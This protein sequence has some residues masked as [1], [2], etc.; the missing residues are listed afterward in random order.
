M[1]ALAAS[2]MAGA[3]QAAAMQET[4]Y[5]VAVSAP[6]VTERAQALKEEAEA[7]YSQPKK[8]RQAVRLLEQSAQLRSDD[9][10]EG[11]ACWLYAGRLRAAMGDYSGARQSLERAAGHAM[12]RGA[13]VDAAHAWIDAAH[14]AVKL[15]NVERVQEYLRRAELLASSPQL[16]ADEASQIR[17]RL[18]G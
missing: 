6:T 15:R 17:A 9:D 12:A 3:A 18:Q 14:V 10:A 13:V 2:V 16:D 5:G 7:L 1:A 4:T 8:W 11:F